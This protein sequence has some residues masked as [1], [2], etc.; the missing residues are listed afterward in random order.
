MD[1]NKDK[2]LKMANLSKYIKQRQEAKK[3]QNAANG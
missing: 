3:V 2:N 1:L